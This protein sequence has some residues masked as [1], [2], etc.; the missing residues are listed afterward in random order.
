MYPLPQSFTDMSTSLCAWGVV[1]VI[2]PVFLG[3]FIARI[4]KLIALA[5]TPRSTR[6]PELQIP[7]DD[8]LL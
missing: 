3:L 5:F 6:H 7:D 1:V 4:D 8:R 2:V